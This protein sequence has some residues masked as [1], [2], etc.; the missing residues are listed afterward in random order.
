MVLVKNG[1]CRRTTEGKT[2]I[3]F[4]CTRHA[5]SFRLYQPGY[6]TSSVCPDAYRLVMQ[7]PLLSCRQLQSTQIFFVFLVLYLRNAFPH[8][9]GRRARE[10]NKKTNF[11]KLLR[12]LRT[13]FRVYSEVIRVR[14]ERDVNTR[15][16]SLHEVIFRSQEKVRVFW[17]R[18][19]MTT[20]V[21]PTTS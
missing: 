21:L 7:L 18:L 5:R 14:C 3:R 11:L 17:C 15:M 20:F 4:E 1:N 6:T 8:R 13:S 2:L 9:W 16:R 12:R 19:F 10:R